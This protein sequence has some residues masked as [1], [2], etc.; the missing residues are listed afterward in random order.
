MPRDSLCSVCQNE[1][2][3]RGL[4]LYEVSTMNGAV[5]VGEAKTSA[6][7]APA[8]FCRDCVGP[9]KA[10]ELIRAGQMSNFCNPHW[11]ERMMEQPVEG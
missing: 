6:V 5:V 1:H 8:T 10:V 7:A 3:V 4:F 9:E 11:F 2:G